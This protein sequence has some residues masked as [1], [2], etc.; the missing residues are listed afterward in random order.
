MVILV[1]RATRLAQFLDKDAKE[2]EATVRFGFETDTGDRT[3]EPRSDGL[4]RAARPLTEPELEGVLTALRGEIRQ[5]PPM[6]SAK[7]VAGKKLYELAREGIEIERTAVRVTIEHLETLELEMA[8]DSI[9]TAKIFVRCS[10]GTY[11]RTLAEDIGRKLGVG[12]HV[13]ELRRISAGRFHV[14]N[15]VK[16]PDLKKAG[17][18]DEFLL[19]VE[20]A[21]ESLAPFVLRAD[22]VEKTRNGMSTRVLDESFA[23]DQAIKMVE[24]GGDLVAI[25][26]YDPLENSV[27]PK[28][29]LV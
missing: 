4:D 1:G 6:Y 14:N 22:R 28:I 18:P 20:T 2:Y 10:A 13:A 17:N 11:I 15:S 19:P 16:L 7:K 24:E 26:Y 23:S 12:A 3:G 27:R 9:S 21:V 5:T 8:K 25:G 29:V